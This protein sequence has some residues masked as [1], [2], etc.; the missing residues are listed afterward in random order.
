S[1]PA[2]FEF[3]K[4]S[5]CKGCHTHA[6][7]H[8]DPKNPQGKWASNQCLKCHAKPGDKGM[9]NQAELE[10]EWHGPQSDFPLRKQHAGLACTKCHKN[11]AAGA[12]ALTTFEDES[13]E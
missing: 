4:D 12:K 6:T 9:R 3:F 5:A 11:R 2:D 7:A 10:R 8:A 1:G 13:P